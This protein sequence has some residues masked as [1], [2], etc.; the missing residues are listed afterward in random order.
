MSF[1]GT[2]SQ[3]DQFTLFDP[4]DLVDAFVSNTAMCGKGSLK[5]WASIIASES[6]FALFLRIA[7]HTQK[8][9]KA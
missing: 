4:I 3:Y 5:L 8:T 7:I 2:V 1:A 6:K 9:T